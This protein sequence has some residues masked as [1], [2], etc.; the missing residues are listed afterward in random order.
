MARR[1]SLGVRLTRLR[2]RS[3]SAQPRRCAVR[4]LG[5]MLNVYGAV[6]LVWRDDLGDIS[7]DP[8]RLARESPGSAPHA[9]APYGV[10]VDSLPRA[11]AIPFN[12]RGPGATRSRSS[13][14]PVGRRLARRVP[15]RAGGRIAASKRRSPDPTLPRTVPFARCL[16]KAR[17]VIRMPG[18]QDTGA[19]A[20][21]GE[22]LHG[23]QEVGG[24]IPPGST[25]FQSRTLGP[26]ARQHRFHRVPIV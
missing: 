8:A 15:T 26:S 10:R 23:M 4:F 21:L 1:R 12:P 3:H 24:S 17:S 14:H 16:R 6:L 9:A 7:F 22:R 11:F 5:A 13:R 18:S 20:Q 2:A 19:I 25:T